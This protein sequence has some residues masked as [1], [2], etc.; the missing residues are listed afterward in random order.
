[1]STDRWK[2]LFGPG[3]KTKESAP[4]V[5]ASVAKPFTRTVTLAEDKCGFLRDIGNA[6]HRPLLLLALEATRGSPHPIAELGA[7]DN[8]TPYLAKL[9]ARE[10]RNTV[11]FE[12]NKQW[13]DKFAKLDGKHFSRFC[14]SWDHAPI[15]RDWS[16]VLI[17]HA[18]EARRHVDIER[19]ANKAEII[20]IHDSEPE[21]TAYMLGKIWPLF[22]YRADICVERPYANSSVVSNSIDVTKWKGTRFEGYFYEVT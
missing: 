6:S 21:A 17:D 14:G 13:S 16:V 9:A 22:K 20:V 5:A 15:D 3:P 2:A 1:M 11:S 8:T 10:Q 18:P 12:N 19:L 4:V 7:G